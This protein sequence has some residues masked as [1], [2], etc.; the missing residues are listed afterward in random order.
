LPILTLF[1][2]FVERS[3]ER[4]PA[5]LGASAAEN[6]ENLA[7]QETEMATPWKSDRNVTRRLFVGTALCAA[8]FGAV[9]AARADVVSDWNEVA[10]KSVKAAVPS[11]AAQG[12]PLAIVAASV[13]D[14]VN[15]IRREYAPYF[16]PGWGPNGARAEAAAAQA[17]Y[18]ALVTLFPTRKADFDAQLKRSLAQI[19]GSHGNSQSVLR[20]RRWGEQVARRVLDWR[21]RDGFDAVLPPYFGGNEPGVWRSVPHGDLPATL[22]QMAVMVPFAMRSHDQFRPAPPPALDSAEYAAAMNEVKALG[23]ADSSYRT[24]EQTEIAR[25]WQACDMAD[26]NRAARGAVPA[27]YSL[28]ARARLFAL[29]NIAIADALIFGMDGKYRYNLWRPHHAVRLA[30]T[31]GNPLTDADPAWSA[32]IVA[33]RHQEY[34]STHSCATGAA[35]RVLTRLLGDATPITIASPG[36]PAFAKTYPNFR[37]AADEVAL[38]RIWAGIHFRFSVATGQAGGFRVADYILET[39]LTPRRDHGR[40]GGDQ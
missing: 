38:A 32:L 28:A 24:P 27:G 17:A 22:P 23:R 12:R 29:M 39:F 16:V 10:E 35:M 13:Y 30:D 2:G 18:T 1:A 3:G 40:R 19:P 6:R 5:I 25:L 26:L 37:A 9:P 8:I 33:P 14:A 7:D 20:G 11:P 34:P 31:D 4:R 21:S 15:G 36:Y